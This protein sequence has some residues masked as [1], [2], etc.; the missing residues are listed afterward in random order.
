MSLLTCLV[1]LGTLAHFLRIFHSL[2]LQY[3]C[4]IGLWIQA[5]KTGPCQQLTVRH[6]QR[7]QEVSVPWF[8]GCT[9]QRCVDTSRTLKWA[10]RT[11]FL[12]SGVGRT[13]SCGQPHGQYM[14]PLGAH[15]YLTLPPSPHVFLGTPRKHNSLPGET[16]LGS[17]G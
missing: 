1:R 11:G 2:L 7:H 5:C 17:S 4:R 14:A 6:G 3:H 9:P 15:H 10:A 8:G 13:L 12:E 16:W